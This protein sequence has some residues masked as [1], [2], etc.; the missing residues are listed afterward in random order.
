MTRQDSVGSSER[1][2]RRPSVSM[3]WLHIVSVSVKLGEV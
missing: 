3:R 1:P 2:D